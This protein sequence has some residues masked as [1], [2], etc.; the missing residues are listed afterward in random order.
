V[1][2]TASV[3]KA[4]GDLLERIGL[5]NAEWRLPCGPASCDYCGAFLEIPDRVGELPHFPDPGH[6][7]HAVA[8][9]VLRLCKD[10]DSHPNIFLDGLL[11]TQKAS[12]DALTFVRFSKTLGEKRKRKYA[13]KDKQDGGDAENDDSDCGEV[14]DAEDDDS[15]CGEAPC[16]E[17]THVLWLPAEY[18]AVKKRMRMH[19]FD[20]HGESEEIK[21]RLDKGNTDTGNV[22]I[23]IYEAEFEAIKQRKG[24][25]VLASKL[26]A[27]LALIQTMCED[28]DMYWM[29]DNE[30]P[31]AVQSLL[32]SIAGY[33]RN[34]V[35]NH[36]NDDATLGLGATSDPA[37]R[38]C[39]REALVHLLKFYQKKIETS[40][41]DIGIKFNCVP[42]AARTLKRPAAAT[43]AAAGPLSK[44]GRPT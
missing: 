36:K 26:C 21:K 22:K 4:A 15:D 6:G 1:P 12:G 17:N 14:S 44:R 13:D 34:T 7:K 8:I 41:D 31:E 19:C 43:G 32:K 2:K 28:M 18:A 16:A 38:A 30:D 9:E 27:L 40:N 35:L 3:T 29:H 33:W 39:S 23:A 24:P 25:T 20:G 11:A 37:E 42:G 5:A 10:D